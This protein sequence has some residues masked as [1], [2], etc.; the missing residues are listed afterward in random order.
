MVYVKG[1]ENRKLIFDLLFQL[2]DFFSRA[3]QQGH[4][5]CKVPSNLNRV[6][7]YPFLKRAKHFLKVPKLNLM[8]LCCCCIYA[9][10]KQ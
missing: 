2:G 9:S 4:Q 8:M 6:S 3:A 1:P 10:Q 5:T 7:I